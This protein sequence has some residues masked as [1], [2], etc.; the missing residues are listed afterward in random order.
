[1]RA[2]LNPKPSSREADFHSRI[3]SWVKA[4][5][6]KGKTDFKE[7]VWALPG[8]DPALVASSV[9]RLAP[10]NLGARQIARQLMSSSTGVAQTVLSPIG[11]APVPHP[12]DYDWR[13]TKETVSVLHALFGDLTNEE[14]VIVLLGAPSLY[15]ERATHSGRRFL[16]VDKNPAYEEASDSKGT[17]IHADLLRTTPTIKGNLIFADPPWYLEHQLSFIYAASMMCEDQGKVMIACPLVGTRPNIEEEWRLILNWSY[18]LGLNYEGDSEVSVI[19]D[20]PFFER[21]AMR[22]SGL[23][24]NLGSWRRA[25]LSIFSKQRSA[26]I[27]PLSLVPLDS[28]SN[29]SHLGMKIR[30]VGEPSRSFKDPSLR[31]LIPGDILTSVSRRDSR[32]QMADVWTQGNRIF[33]CRGINVL[34][35]ILQALEKGLSPTAE[36]E[37]LVSRKLTEREESLVSKTVEKILKIVQLERLEMS[38]GV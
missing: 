12:L 34:R 24:S 23:P 13:F 37:K 18:A 5:I 30:L 19:Y 22:I 10:R 25:R 16:L 31:S 35:V 8:V 36:V 14:G 29:E 1:M 28:W 15:L 38:T 20:S 9:Q 32:R 17:V 33:S 6:K 21:N 27:S 3:D 11:N 7:L 4:E 2:I 26:T